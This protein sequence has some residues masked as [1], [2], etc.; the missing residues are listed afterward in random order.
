VVEIA[1]FKHLNI[2]NQFERSDLK[3]VSLGFCVQIGVNRGIG[4][5]HLLLMKTTS[6]TGFR[7]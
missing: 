7:G 1:G 3:E 4:E 5:T 6:R 2:Y